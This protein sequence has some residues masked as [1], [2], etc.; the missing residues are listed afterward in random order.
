MYAPVLFGAALT[1]LFQKISY[2]TWGY[3]LQVGRGFLVYDGIL[4]ILLGGEIV[5]SKQL[6][7]I[8][9]LHHVIILGATYYR[10]YDGLLAQ[11]FL[12]ELTIPLLYYVWYLGKWRLTETFLFR[13]LS[14]ATLVFFFG[15]RVVN[16]SYFLVY[17]V[18]KKSALSSTKSGLAIVGMGLLTLMNYYW[19]YC[20]VL[21]FLPY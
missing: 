2:K 10:G 7:L 11:G 21:K 14:M 3:F 19:F 13:F 15:L 20:L 16:F 9:L 8:T 5:S 17:L 18:M 12:S 4:L 6:L 1:Y